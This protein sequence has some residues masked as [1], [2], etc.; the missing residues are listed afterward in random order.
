MTTI[1]DPYFVRARRLHKRAI[2]VDSHC[3]TTRR[4]KDPQWDFS[5]RDRLGHVDLPRLR[6]GGVDAVFLAVWA[7]GPVEPGRG[8]EAANAQIRHIHELVRRHG[9]HLVLAQSAKDARRA[10]ASGRIAILIGIEGGYLIEDS[11]DVLQDYHR[12]GA[13][14]MTL[15][16]GFHTSWADSSGGRGPLEPLHGGLTDFGRDVI[17]EM[18]RLGM[19][20]DVSHASDAALWEVIETS[21]APVVATHSSCRALAPHWRNLSDDLMLGIAATGGVVQINFCATFIDPDFPPIDPV[22]MERWMDSGV[23]AEPLTNHTTTLGLL[24]DHFEHAIE[25]VGPD[26]VGIG[27]DFDGVPQLPKGMEDCSKLPV[28]T[29]EL[30]RRGYD[31]S[32]LVK[33]LGENMLQVMAACEHVA[34]EFVHGKYADKADASHD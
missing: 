25:L 16:H 8:I 17:R 6:E 22:A 2:V 30:L 19:M 27:S 26:H 20:V 24:V 9:E 5:K 12:N 18:N 34:G 21:V 3:D 13:M 31:E 32:L 28:L 7:P 29:A 23:C 14:Y 4:L 1:D 11:L 10:K 15:T 33:V